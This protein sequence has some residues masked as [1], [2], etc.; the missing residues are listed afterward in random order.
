MV[1]FMI[2]LV[3][4]G[5]SA[6]VLY[7]MLATGPHWGTHITRFLV[8]YAVLFGLCVAFWR[9][10]RGEGRSKIFWAVLGFAAVFRVIIVFSPP[11]L[12]D[13]IYRYIWDGRVL[14]SGVNPY[15]YAPTDPALTSLRD[16]LWPL[17]NNPALPTIYPPVLQVVFAAAAFVSPSVLG[18]KL[19]FLLMDLGAVVFLYFALRKLGRSRWI[20]LYAWHPLPILEISGSGHSEA[21]GML[22]LCA[23]L[24]GVVHRRWFASGLA[25]LF[26][27]LVK[28]L[29]LAALPS[30]VK[31]LKF[32]V[33]WLALI[34]GAAYAAFGFSGVSPLGS[35]N[36]FADKWRANDFLFRLL[37]GGSADEAQVDQA[38][39]I[40]AAC[41]FVVWLISLVRY[42]HWPWVYSWTVAAAFLLSPVLHPWYLLWLLPVGILLKQPAFLLW[43]GTVVLSYTALPGYLESGVWAESTLW[44]WI[45]YTPVLLAIPWQIA[46]EKHTE[47]LN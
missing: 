16:S 9:V 10:L 47:T 46:K 7:L 41:V 25:L 33:V 23:G 29:P 42:K 40:A 3:L 27:G 39:V 31:Q 26:A 8:I 32:R 12:S 43:T 2:R 28:L 24:W 17:I 18:F 13:D 35:L 45:Q 1:F 21:V 22:C 15:L 20:V 11:Y 38:K 14:L 5:V 30:L 4:W 6:S 44:K 19:V 36:T 34:C 37:A